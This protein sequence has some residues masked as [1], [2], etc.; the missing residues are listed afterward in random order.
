M[1]FEKSFKFLTVLLSRH[2]YNCLDMTWVK[3]GLICVVVF[4]REGKF[5]LDVC[6]ILLVIKWEVVRDLKLLNKRLLSVNNLD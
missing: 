3:S 1:M 5:R 6:Q 4:Y 2:P